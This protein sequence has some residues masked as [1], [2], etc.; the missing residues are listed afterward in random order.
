MRDRH[1]EGQPG[2]SSCHRTVDL[3]PKHCIMAFKLCGLRPT[4]RNIFY[5]KTKFTHAKINIL[6]L[7][8]LCT[9]I[10]PIIY[11]MR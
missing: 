4:V 10:C 2:C 9:N 5:I 6:I 1:P 8:L 7:V 11:Q 3:M